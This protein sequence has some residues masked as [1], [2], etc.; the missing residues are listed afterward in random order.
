MK[1]LAIDIGAESGRAVVGELL[2]GR[3]TVREVNRFANRPI[4]IGETLRWNDRQ[5]VDDLWN[6]VRC[7]DSEG[8]GSVGIDTWAIDFT[9]LDIDGR[10]IQPP[11]HYRDSQTENIMEEVF[12][13]VPRS[14]IYAA[15]GIQ[16]LR[17]NTLYQLYAM[18]KRHDPA[19]AS[20]FRFLTVP[21]YLNYVLTETPP[22]RT[23]CEYTNATT[24]QFFNPVAGRWAK[25]LLNKLDLKI[26]APRSCPMLC[27]PQR[28]SGPYRDRT[29]K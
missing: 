6:S 5:I 7:G 25:P 17:F 23:V 9:L 28:S 27:H 29:S 1:H 3:L 26:H 24:T 12:G 8:V 22:G 14:Q 4:H 2:D 15:T 20:A 18:A 13:I 16:F 10:V 19:L 21:D 11:Y